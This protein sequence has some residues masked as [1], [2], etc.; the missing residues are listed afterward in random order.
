MK[1]MWFGAALLIAVLAVSQFGATRMEKF[2]IPEAENLKQAAEYALQGNWSRARE[3]ADE[4][5]ASWEQ[6]RRITASVSNHEPMDSIDA[7]FA[8]LKL[9]G[10]VQEPLPFS[11]ACVRL[12]EHL[13]ALGQ[14]HSLKW[15]NL[16]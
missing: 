4:A 15:W 3:L 10:K 13:L 14:E 1:R 2:R 5:N 6:M 11:G 12:A 9:Y 16:L 7:L 8:E